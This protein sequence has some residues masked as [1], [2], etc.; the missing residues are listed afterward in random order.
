M[1][2]SAHIRICSRQ[3]TGLDRAFAHPTLFDIAVVAVALNRATASDRSPSAIAIAPTSPP[4]RHH[5]YRGVD[6]NQ[7]RR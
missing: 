5:R 7:I 2:K 4:I 3:I 6:N 1:D